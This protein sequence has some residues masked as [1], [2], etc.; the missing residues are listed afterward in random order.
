MRD[1]RRHI[2]EQIEHWWQIGAPDVASIHDTGNQDL[3]GWQAMTM[4]EI[5]VFRA[6]Y[7]VKSDPTNRKR[8]QRLIAFT[9]L[10]EKSREEQFRLSF[11]CGE[12][13]VGLLKG[14]QLCRCAVLDE[15]GFIELNPTGTHRGEPGNDFTIE[16]A[17][18]AQ[19]IIQETQSFVVG[20]AYQHQAAWADRHRLA[21]N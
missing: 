9:Y 11:P 14:G 7:D 21:G 10:A 2:I 13:F 4:Q 17:D 6:A 15:T 12:Q 1:D 20:F 16:G 19:G 5:T 8:D 18:T 3:V